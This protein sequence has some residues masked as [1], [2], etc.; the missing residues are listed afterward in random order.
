M[1][2]VVPIKVI[3]QNRLRKL[4]ISRRVREGLA[5]VWWEEIVGPEVARVTMP[6]SVREGVLWVAAESAAWANELSL[7]VP[8]IMRKISARIGRGLIKEI[9][10]R[11]A[12]GTMSQGRGAPDRVCAPAAGVAAPYTNS[13]GLE[14]I[15]P[16][17]LEY[18][19]RLC[20]GITDEALRKAFCKA[21]L[22]SFALRRKRP[23]LL[24]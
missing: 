21:I 16:Q 23:N 20:N 1:H 8:T 24:S 10:F 2:S 6:L 9:R 7:M 22:G 18:A 14:E 11:A 5:L 15:P 12:D 19:L 4:G 13:G 3:L 17:D